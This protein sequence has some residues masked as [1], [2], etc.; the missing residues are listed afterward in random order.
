[1]KYSGTRRWALVLF[2]LGLLLV[3]GAGG[4]RDTLA[5]GTADATVTWG[6]NAS[7]DGY[8]ADSKLALPLTQLWAVNLH[9]GVSYPLVVGDR[10]YVIVGHG[11]DAGYGAGLYGLDARNG[12]VLWGPLEQGGPYWPSALAYDHDQVFSVNFDGILRAYDAASGTP[13]WSAKMPVQYAFS[14]P[15]T[16]YNGVVYLTGSGSGTTLYAVDE[17]NGAILWQAA[18]S[19]GSPAVNDTAVFSAVGCGATAY[20][21]RTGRVLWQQSEECTASDG[22]E[23]VLHQDRVY[24]A[25]GRDRL[26]VLDA[27]TGKQIQILAASSK[28]AFAGGQ[29]FALNGATLQAFDTAT[30]R[31]EWS[32]AGAGH[33][34]GPPLVDDTA[35]YIQEGNQIHVL[36]PASGRELAKQAFALPETGE[37]VH[38]VTTGLGASNG[39]LMVPYNQ[40]LIA[41]GRAGSGGAPIPTAAP[42][43]AAPPAPPALPASDTTDAS[44]TYQINAAHTGSIA[45]DSLTPPLRQI[46]NLDLGPDQGLSYPLVVGD[47]TYVV[48][49]GQLQARNL[50]TGELVW[51][52]IAQGG[53]YSS[54]MIAYDQGQIFA[55]NFDGILR[56]FDA[57]TGTPTWSTKL[58]G[59]Y[60]FSS[61]PSA[62]NGVVYT[63]GAGSGG[64]MYAVRE[65]NGEVLWTA[66]VMNGD[67]SSPAVGDNGVYVAYAC[68]QVYGFGLAQGAPLWHHSTDCEGGGGATPAYYN[69]K[70]YAPDSG[71]LYVLDAATGKEIQIYAANG[72]PS[73]SGGRGFLLNGGTLQAFNESTGAVLWSFA[74]AGDL[75]SLPIVVH[76]VLYIGGTGGTLYGL[77]PATGHQVFSATIGG[78]NSGSAAG[79][80]SLAAGNGTLVIVAGSRLVAYTSSGP[81][82][83]PAPTPGPPPGGSAAPRRFP[84][85]GHILRGSFRQ[86]WETHGGLAQQ[87][88]PLTDEFTE[89]NKL[90]GQRYTVQYFERAVF[91][92]HPNNPA[93]SQVLLSQL[94]TYRYQQKYPTGAPGQQRNPNDP[95]YFPETGHSLGGSFR[96]YWERHGGLAQ[97]GYPLSDEFP[98]QSAL[99]GQTYTMQYFERAVLEWHPQNRDP[100]TVLGSQLGTFEFQARYPAGPPH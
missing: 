99:D 79:I 31:V 11:A 93:G 26:Y 18:S 40:W 56:A 1:M 89:V 55:L 24:I 16:A 65:T 13:R 36:D 88:Y 97:L 78:G 10:I 38:E 72:T 27:A 22:A 85:T 67:D 100:F 64:T 86:Y 7:H 47:R 34:S 23:L 66:E 15:P 21:P 96:L 62:R 4:A 63:G 2:G 3:I 9:G 74:G 94:G 52:P 95:R 44:V 39:R 76:D 90:D 68:A 50:H 20:E 5:G 37:T 43:P 71:N 58:P 32:F 53:T 35:L 42:P 91:E 46:W 81:V 87:G 61:P 83:G 45:N 84:E 73:F 92:W 14:T 70:V 51:G 80:S 33:L 12:Q 17:S 59:Q 54:G 60:A 98:E 49:G 29:G 19:D 25:A 69:N 28:P 77:D 57:G 30:N 8:L 82:L 6:V 41:F 48:V 75:R